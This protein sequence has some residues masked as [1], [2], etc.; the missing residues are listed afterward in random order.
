MLPFT[1]AILWE[2]WSTKSRYD[3]DVGDSSHGHVHFWLLQIRRVDFAHSECLR[4]EKTLELG[5]GGGGGRGVAINDPQSPKILRVRLKQSKTDQLGK[6]VDV[7]GGCLFCPV[8]GVLA[9]MVIQGS[10]EGSFF[11]FKSSQ[12]YEG[13]VY[14]S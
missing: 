1:P 8:A 11:R 7:F 12:P 4:F 13:K 6:G 3:N 10:D 9:Y 5:G 2:H 14:T